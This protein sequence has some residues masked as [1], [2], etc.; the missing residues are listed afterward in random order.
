MVKLEDLYDLENWFKRFT[1]SK[2]YSPTL[3]Y[4]LVNLGTDDKPQNVNLGLGLV[5]EEK[6]AYIHLL[7]QYKNVFS[8]NYDELKT[9]DT[10]IIQHTIPMIDNEKPVQ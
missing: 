7:R 1:N 2:L 4:E 8:W 5:P 3:N 10:S 6:L 9:Y